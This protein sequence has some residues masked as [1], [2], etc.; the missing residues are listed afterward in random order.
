MYRD[1]PGWEGLLPGASG[2][3]G[4][5]DRNPKGDAP[6]VHTTRRDRPGRALFLLALSLYPAAGV[7]A[8]A[9][10]I[11]IKVDAA[12]ERFAGIVAFVFEKK[13]LMYNLTLEGSK[14]TRLKR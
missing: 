2:Y 9:Q 5:P 12:L 8:S 7:A 6:H 13:G 10:E 1:R 11:D 4:G 3:P 14:F